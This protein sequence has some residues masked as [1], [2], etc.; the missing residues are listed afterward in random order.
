MGHEVHILAASFSHL[1]KE[2]P[3]PPKGN[4]ASCWSEQIDGIHYHWLSTPAY[5]GNG[6]GRVRNIAAFLL[7][8]FSAWKSLS[9]DAKPE[10]IIASSTSPMDTLLARHIV[11]R[12]KA[13]WV[14]EVHDLWPLS[15]I[16][17]N[18]MS[19]AHPFVL[20]CQNAENF[21]YKHADFVVS[22]LP[23]V[24]DHMAAHGLDLQKLHI[25]P[26][27]TS[28]ED[29][30]SSP[31]PLPDEIAECLQSIHSKGRFR[32]GYAGS[33]GIPNALDELLDT[34]KLLREEAVDFVLVGDGHEKKRLLQRVEQEQI[35]NVH[36]FPPIP[37]AAIPSFLQ[38]IDLAYLGWKP[39]PIY[40][41]GIAPNKLFDYMMA[42]RPVLHVVDAGNDP[43]KDSGC[44]HSIPPGNP[45][46]IAKEIRK[47]M[48]QS[49]HELRLLGEKGKEFVLNHHTYPVLA[50]NFLHPFL[51]A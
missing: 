18:G 20:L 32:V 33:H 41:F 13:R 44:G 5:A 14:Y 7:R 12:T 45:Q 9:G 16:E 37:K 21:A 50:R 48:L 40:R 29:W 35:H 43:V 24:H 34:A 46:H 26:N 6:V 36:M 42:E 2:N 10:L 27:G 22:M 3:M 11:K 47:M 17:L 23:K 28:P 15:L 30:E 49:E 19:K 38:H 4:K 8:A 1:R 51:N 25:I 31:L 39:M